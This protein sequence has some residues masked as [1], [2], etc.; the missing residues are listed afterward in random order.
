MPQAFLGA[1]PG[2]QIKDASAPALLDN[3]DVTGDVTGTAVAVNFPGRVAVLAELTA[4]NGTTVTLDLEVQGADDESFTENVVSLGH[5]DS[6]AEGDEGETRVLTVH[7][8]KPWMRVVATETNLTDTD[9][10]VTV[11]PADH[12]TGNTRSA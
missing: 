4:V 2:T 7:A 5:F 8:W 1:N 10:T 11:V 9:I 3:A 12:L 6:I